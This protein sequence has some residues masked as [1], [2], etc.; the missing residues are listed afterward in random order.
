MTAALVR[1]QAPDGDFPIPADPC[2]GEI[3]YAQTNRKQGEGAFGRFFRELF[4]G[5]S[6]TYVGASGIAHYTKGLFGAPKV[7]VVPY[8]K[9]ARLTASEVRIMRGSTYIHTK[10]DYEWLGP[11]DGSPLPAE[12]GLEKAGPVLLRLETLTF[13]NITPLP[14]A[15]VH[16]LEHAERAWTAW[17]FP[18]LVAA[19]SAGP[20]DFP[21]IGNYVVRVSREEIAW[22]YPGGPRPMRRAAR[23][24]VREFYLARGR[25]FISPKGES[26]HEIAFVSLGNF[27]ALLLLL[28]ELGYPR[29]R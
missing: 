13:A 8:E 10:Y 18:R 2:L 7:V 11:K 28:A 19:S 26:D 17:I 15:L 16:A 29:V 14:D 4:D 22:G 24:D 23:G 3:L 12:G 6:C 20:V 5:T 21:S 9:C 27:K 1:A 25:L